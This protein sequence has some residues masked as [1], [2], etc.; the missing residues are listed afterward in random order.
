MTKGLC[1]VCFKSNLNKLGISSEF[2][3][4]DAVHAFANPSNQKFDVE[5]TKDAHEKV[6]I[7]FTSVFN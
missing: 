6:V 1:H 3:S 4:Y 5:A 7:F 2:H